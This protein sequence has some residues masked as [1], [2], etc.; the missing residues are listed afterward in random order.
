MKELLDR[1]DRW[2][3]AHCPSE[4]SNFLPGVT[5]QRFAAFEDGVGLPLPEAFKEL[6]LWRNGQKRCS[7]RLFGDAYNVYDFMTLREV[8]ESHEEL[9]DI[10]REIKERD[11]IG[12]ATWWHPKWVPFL[13]ADGDHFCVDTEGT[14]G[15]SRGQVICFLHDD[16]GLIESAS[17][18]TW[19]ETFVV[20][21]EG[22]M[23]RNAGGWLELLNKEDFQ[24]L[25][26][27]MNPGY[28]VLLGRL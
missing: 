27:R 11:P 22:G 21:L 23:W 17:L 8:Q 1:L 18:E 14:H 6:Y 12:G 19:L 15:G 16:S 25:V 26:K 3:K 24:Q 13:S 2:F 20:S 4:Y 28:P 7:G 9:N 5:A 10:L